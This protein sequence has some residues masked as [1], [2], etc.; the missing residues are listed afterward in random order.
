MSHYYWLEC[1]RCDARMN[2]SH[3][4]GLIQ[5]ETIVE[6]IGLFVP[7]REHNSS[8]LRCVS[9]EH[10]RDATGFASDHAHCNAFEVHS[11]YD[12]CV[13]RP[14]VQGLPACVACQRPARRRGDVRGL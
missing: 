6:L 9:G 10:Y 4:K 3:N 12:G 5:L 13:S 1:R 11:E 8:D 7:A 2:G 14:R